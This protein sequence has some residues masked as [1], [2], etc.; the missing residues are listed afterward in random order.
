MNSRQVG[1]VEGA[2][3]MSTHDNIGGMPTPAPNNDWWCSQLPWEPRQVFSGGGGA[4]LQF[5][6]ASDLKLH[7]CADVKN[8][9]GSLEAQAKVSLKSISGPILRPQG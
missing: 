1:K 3:C 5:Q 2:A 8:G 9:N 7:V 4:C 6:D